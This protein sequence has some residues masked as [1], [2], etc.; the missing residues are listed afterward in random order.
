MAEEIKID[1]PAN[2]IRHISAKDMKNADL[3]INNYYIH[4]NHILIY[5]TILFITNVIIILL[6]M[7]NLVYSLLTLIELIYI[8]NLNYVKNKTNNI[9]TDKYK[10][11]NYAYMEIYDKEKVNNLVKLYEVYN[12]TTYENTV[13]N[14]NGKYDD[15]LICLTNEQRRIM[16]CKKCEEIII[17]IGKNKYRWMYY[18]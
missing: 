14:L 10:I 3:D 4:K 17:Y 18:L 1:I 5:K 6:S 11:S 7:Y 16:F 8:F 12:N 13:V 15:E 2:P 9:V